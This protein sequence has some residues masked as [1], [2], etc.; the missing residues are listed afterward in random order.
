MKAHE[1]RAIGDQATA[2]A[3]VDVAVGASDERFL[4]PH[5]DVIAL[6]GDFFL[7]DPVPPA[8]WS[9][10]L[11]DLAAIPGDRGHAP[12]TRDEIVC[13]LKV[14]AVDE[15][16]R[17]PRFEEG[18]E[19]AHAEL[20][21]SAARSE[22][23]R[24]VRD[25]F[26]AL[27]AANA[28]HFVD[29][30][31]VDEPFPRLEVSRFGSARTAY[32]VLHE[33]ALEEACRLGRT[34]GDMSRAMAREAAAQH[35]LTDA[36]ASGH[37]RTPIAAIRR[38]W[39]DRYPEFWG[40]LQHKIA[41][42]TAAALREVAKP[43]RLLRRQ[44]LYDRT[45]GAVRART[46]DYPPV[47][48]GDLLGRVFHDW[49]NDHGLVLENGAMLFG[50]GHLDEGVG[51]T[52][53]VAAVRAGN[54]DVEVAYGLGASGSRLSG[55]ALYATV[56]EATG[57]EPDTFAAEACLPRPSPD[58]PALNWRAR[59]IDELWTTPIAG[60]R[61]PTVGAAVAAVLEVGGEV[62]RRL[63]CLGQGVVEAFD[64]LEVPVLRGWLSRKA[65][66]AYHRG[67]IEGL[68]RDPRGSIA[69]VVE[70]AGGRPVKEWV[71]AGA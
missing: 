59:D 36:F 18:G 3:L 46:R 64:V 43:L 34:G 6:S 11:F 41:A 61:G 69:A 38:F 16:V 12:G 71:T 1:H 58:N 48:L 24:R 4:L 44:A 39:H 33:A 62:S 45:L 52:L 53:A 29:P 67:F 51:R 30:W 68:A 60:S 14:M 57:A 50:D 9:S 13:A 21:P 40:S 22:V 7:A 27:A 10:G 31:G 70:T 26:L 63:D 56:R 5:G 65:C 55:P 32:R 28:D 2:G 35:Y 54:D 19:F 23:E 49:D 42:D 37:L 25:R 20:S 15:D 8:P 47:S 17:D 66:H